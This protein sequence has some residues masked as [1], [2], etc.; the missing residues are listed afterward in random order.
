MERCWVNASES[1]KKVIL[2][3]I[4]SSPPDSATLRAA[5]TAFNA[6]IDDGNPLDTPARKY[7]K[8]LTKATKRLAV[9]VA[10][11]RKERNDQKEVLSKRRK[12]RSGK[13]AV[14]KG[15]FILTTAEIR[16]QV[17]AAELE[18]LHKKACKEAPKKRKQQVTTLEDEVES[19]ESTEES[20]SSF[21]DCIRVE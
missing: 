17:I 6:C 19:V 9:Q 8:G 14:I 5:N 21:S 7:A 2:Q 16:D 13:K 15:H 18:T 10:I 1:Y 20:N 11:L 3:A 4:T 12:Q